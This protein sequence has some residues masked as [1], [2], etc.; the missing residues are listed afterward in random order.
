[1]KFGCFD[2]VISVLNRFGWDL[3]EWVLVF[4]DFW[5]HLVN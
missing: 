2:L 1:M 5:I 4:G 3:T